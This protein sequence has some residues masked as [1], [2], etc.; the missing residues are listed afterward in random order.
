LLFVIESYVAQQPK[1][2]TTRPSAE[3][4]AGIK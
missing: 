2:S 4:I 3:R 1:R